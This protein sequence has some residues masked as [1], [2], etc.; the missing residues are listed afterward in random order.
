[1]NLRFQITF[2]DG[3]NDRGT[4]TV[5]GPDDNVWSRKDA[6]I[7]ADKFAWK[8]TMWWFIH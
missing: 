7:W 1:M 5:N 3:A 6:V 4:V 8:K 2:Y